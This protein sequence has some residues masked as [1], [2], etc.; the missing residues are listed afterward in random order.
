M[1]AAQ[2]T[3]W[4][5]E[6][7]L[8][9]LWE[10]IEAHLITG[11]IAEFGLSELLDAEVLALKTLETTTF[12]CLEAMNGAQGLSWEPMQAGCPQKD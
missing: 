3:R 12:G 2:R 10:A 7:E 6:A 8:A 1:L 5:T 11:A 4:H 9:A